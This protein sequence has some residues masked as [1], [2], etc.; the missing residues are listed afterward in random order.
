MRLTAIEALRY[1]ALENGCLSG[2]GGGL[3]VVLGPNES[4]KSTFTALTRHVLYGYPDGRAK[5]RG[6]LPPAGSRHARL[7]FASQDGE[8][9]IE[10][11]EGARRGPVTVAARRGP[12]RPGLLAEVVGGVSEQTYR[13]VFGFGLDELAEIE[14]RDNADIVARLYAAGTGLS[15]NPMDVRKE[16]DSRAQ[17]LWAP[18]A[19]RPKVNALTS[20]MKALRDAIR[21]LE[22]N[23]ASYA[24]DQARLSELFDEIEPVRS[25]RDELEEQV[26]VLQRSAQ[27]VHDAVEQ[28]AGLKER[29]AEIDSEAAE[30][31]R[32]LARIE[33]DEAARSAAPALSAVL[34][35]A[36]AF[37]DRLTAIANAEAAAREFEREAAVVGELPA[38]AADSAENRAAVERWRD[39]L[40]DRRREAESAERAAEQA[41]ARARQMESEG[42]AGGAASGTPRMLAIA[43]LL[44]GVVAA[45]AGA[46]LGQWIAALLGVG[47]A[48]GGV[49]LLAGR[50]KAAVPA[51]I[52]AEA[53]RLGADARALSDVAAAARS[54]ADADLAEWRGWLADRGLDV[55]GD[56]PVAVR[57][58]LDDLR[59]KSRLLGEQQ[60][61]TEDAR[62]ERD[63]AE[64][65]ILRLVDVAR[66]FDPSANQI[67]PLSTAL[68]LSAKAKSTVDRAMEADAER[69]SVTERLQ[70]LLSEREVV[71]TS[72]AERVKII[73][74]VTGEYA[75]GD[76]PDP[77]SRLESLA[78]RLKGDLAE[79]R[80]R[81]E[82]LATAAS[83]LRGRLDQ[84]GRDDAM[85]LARQ[86]REG[87]RAQ[88]E[89][90]AD[91]YLVTAAAV[92]L[93]DR[94]RER[95]ER[96]RQ[97]EVVRS[98]ARVFSAMTGGRYRDL[99]IPLDDTGITVVASDG[100]VRPTVELSRGTAE[101]L[102]LA[103]RVG[104]I[105]SLGS[106]GSSLPVLMDDIIVNFDAE[107]RVGAAAAVAELA[108][109]RQVVYFTC[110]E[111]TAELLQEAVPGATSITLDR[112]S[113]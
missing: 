25:L 18:R 91:Q 19:Q 13:V 59:E 39:R 69:R 70:R 102:Y 103:L 112:C 11:V 53:A 16:L 101:Q 52:N 105:S 57:Q 68:E 66:T 2:L 65:W 51:A 24:A 82:V 17:A 98:A 36:S 5:E 22:A 96:E 73:E 113:L 58:L 61:H 34:E 41:D 31:E 6:Y 90:A 23:A 64:A 8:W 104:L 75:I 40:A 100:T 32:V 109:Q 81:Y 44:V 86:K 74:A 47:V 21:E 29:L 88:A 33:V 85:A 50:N 4:G 3:T 107:R 89:Q 7:V 80:D 56:D 111:S 48:A 94:A 76:D 97:P 49:Y 54:R 95:F 108:A 63:A 79:A 106:M 43:L 60:R 20:G 28:A 71:A 55:Y 77:S 67:P 35:D 9:A 42:S 1:G 46:L 93:V 27:K 10:R 15:V 110:H 92:R 37:R 84:E 72:A 26:L 83:E 62:R 12:E 45:A 87:L 30:L 38:G 78:L 99:R 14:H